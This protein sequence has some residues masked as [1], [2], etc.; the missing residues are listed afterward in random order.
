MPQ[1]VSDPVSAPVLSQVN[2][3]GDSPMCMT[4]ISL[5]STPSELHVAG[6]AEAQ[7]AS[8][9]RI[10][11]PSPDKI[12]DQLAESVANSTSRSSLSASRTLSEA[13]KILGYFAVN[14][15]EKRY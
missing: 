5:T 2:S 6:E 11:V 7:K 4:E 15:G 9:I 14:T 10:P 13:G 12:K 3:N 8:A 1:R